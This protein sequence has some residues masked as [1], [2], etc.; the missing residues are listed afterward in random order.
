MFIE[1]NGGGTDRIEVSGYQASDVSIDRHGRDGTD[2][3]VTFSNSDDQITLR[4]GLLSG[5]DRIEEIVL[6]DSDETIS[7]ADVIARLTVGVKTD[8]R[9]Y[10]LGSSQSE[11]LSGGEGDDFVDG[12]G[13]RDTYLY[14]STH[15]DDR[16]A[17]SSSSTNDLLILDDLNVSDIRQI[18]AI[19]AGS[20]DLALYFQEQRDRVVL[21]GAL[22]DNNEGIDL[23]RF[24]DGNGMDAYRNARGFHQL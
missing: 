6:L 20:A 19:G 23:I 17:D 14:S 24:A 2:L 9:D 5:A 7:L 18:E 22:R 16:F 3:I 21:V 10:I 13:G 4:N 12:E 15:D 11:T 8:G 1:D